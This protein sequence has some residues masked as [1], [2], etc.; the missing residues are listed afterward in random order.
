MRPSRNGVRPNSPPQM[1]S[2]SSSSPRC[3]RSLIRAATGLSIVAHFWSARP[4]CP[5]PA[6]VPWKSQPQ[7]NSCTNRTPCSTSR[8]ASRQLLAKL[9]PA[10][11][12]AIG[13]ERFFRLAR[14]VHHLGHRQSACG[15][16]ARTAR[17]GSASRDGPAP[18]LASRSGRASA[19]SVSRRSLRGPCPADRKHTAPDRPSSGTARPDRPTAESRC[20]TKLLPPLG[21]TPLEISTTKPGRFSFSEP[22]PYV[23][24]EPIEGRPC[25]RRAGEQQQFGRRRD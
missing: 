7:S 19:S 17:C 15:R 21:C 23:T 25:A 5:G 6:P 8:R 18:W 4:R 22:R 11:L 20:R 16:P 14:N 10:G 24:H 3:L 12:G 1:I 2:V 13:L 9:G